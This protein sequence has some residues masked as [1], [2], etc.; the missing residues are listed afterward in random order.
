MKE[1]K[2]V[3]GDKVTI[4]NDGTIL[5]QELWFSKKTFKLADITALGYKEYGLFYNGAVSI[6]FETA[7]AKPTKLE[8]AFG[9]KS[10]NQFRELY[11]FLDEKTG[12]SSQKLV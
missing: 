11:Q 3:T 8:I 7:D 6:T 2:G 12:L 9:R 10:R 5:V 4:K 1:Y